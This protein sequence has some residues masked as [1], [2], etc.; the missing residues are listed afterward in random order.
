MVFFPAQSWAY[1]IGGQSTQL[2]L[3][4]WYLV[5][6]LLY[7]TG[8]T[9]IYIA[10]VALAPQMSMDE[11]E[12]TSIQLISTF[13]NLI[14]GGAF[15]FIPAIF[16]TDTSIDKI[17]S[18]QILVI[19]VGVICFIPWPILI[20]TIKERKEFIPPVE[21]Q[22]TFWQNFAHVFR[23][24]SGRHYVFYDGISVFL[25]NCT[26]VG[27]IF[28][29]EWI[30]GMKA[31]YNPIPDFGFANVIPYLIGPIAAFLLEFL[32]YYGFRRNGM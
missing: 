25:F 20:R 6:Q 8:F 28:T 31:E 10:H 18:F 29:L 15:T 11:K 16:L 4:G 17:R 5:T 13:I 32:S 21:T 22:A 14:F 7:D 2:L 23:N 1:A 24:P 30:F 19:I 26:F 27:L 3:A 12:R 9:I